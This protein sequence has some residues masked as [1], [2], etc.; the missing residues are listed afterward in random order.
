MRF[1]SCR[2]RLRHRPLRAPARQ[3]QPA[4][5]PDNLLQIE[6]LLLH[7]NPP[8][9]SSQIWSKTNICFGS[10]LPEPSRRPPPRYPLDS[11]SGLLSQGLLR[12]PLFGVRSWDLPTLCYVGVALVMF[13]A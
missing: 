8:S 9:L 4:S 5:T 10:V 3:P 1:A 12:S 6:S 7:P 2:R 11:F 13:S